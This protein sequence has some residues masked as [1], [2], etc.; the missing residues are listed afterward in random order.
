MGDRDAIG[1]STGEAA[2]AAVNAASAAQQYEVIDL[3]FRSVIAGV[4]AAV[5]EPPVVTGV[6]MFCE[7]HVYDLVR[8]RAHMQDVGTGAAAGGQAAGETDRGNA[9]RFHPWPV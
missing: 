6:S 2:Q 3:E 8:L 9:E 5:V 1:V 7:Q 4:S